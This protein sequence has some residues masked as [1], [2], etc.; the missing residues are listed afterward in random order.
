MDDL[1][2]D[3]LAETREMLEALG[4][5][6]V[7][8]EDDP[9]DRAR[10]DAIFRF[11]H[12]VKGNCGFFEFPRLEALSHAAEDALAD[13]RANRRQADSTLVSA[14]LAILDRIGDMADAIEEGTEFPAGGDEGL[15]AALEP[16][17]DVSA[18]LQSS[19]VSGDDGQHKLPS[20]QRS[21]RL[22][23]E[24]LDRVMSGVSDMV[25][26]RNELARRL[27]ESSVEA[28]VGEP[29]ERLSAII[30][31]VRDA[32]TRTRMQ[33][34]ESLFGG[35]P[36]LVRDLSAELGKQTMIDVDGGEVE[37]DREMI[38]IIRNPLT[39]I[40][41]NAIDHGIETPAARL[42]AG[43]RDMGLLSITARQ[44]G[45]QILIDI[46]DDGRGIDDTRLVEKAVA[47]GIIGAAHATRLSPRERTALIFEPG[48]STAETVTAISGRGVGMDVV[49]ANIERIGGTIEVESI[50]GTGTRFSL[51][52]PLTLTI[53]P[54]LT[55]SIAGQRFA[56]PRSS[57]EEIARVDAGTLEMSRVGGAMLAKIRERR[58]PCLALADLLRMDSGVAD[59]E[60]TLIVLR[61]TGGELFALAVDRV[62]DH[63]ELVV[64]PVAPAIIAAGIYAGTT[65][66]DDG[67]PILLLEATG[68]ARAGG[69]QFDAL[70]RSMR[71]AG[72][73]EAAKAA[74]TTPVLLFIGRDGRRKAMPMAVVARIEEVGPGAVETDGDR[75]RVV[76]GDRILPLAGTDEV[77]LPDEE[78]R[79]FRL[80]DGRTEIGYAIHEALGI[81]QIK[82]EFVAADHSGDIAGVVLID[83]EPTSV[84]APYKLF[85]RHAARTSGEAS[86]VCHLPADDPWIQNF[87]RPMV[88]AAGYRI[89]NDGDGEADLA[90]MTQPEDGVAISARKVIRLRSE[91]ADLQDEP[92]SIYRYDHAGLLSALN[93]SRGRQSL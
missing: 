81:R 20:S 52:V 63:E 74:R 40:I 59:E 47:A 6:L 36:R 28:S 88:E 16:E 4:G 8:W 91:P 27:R 82:A 11:F 76:I 85:A 56:I 65:L 54:A 19:L 23:V 78:L 64:K 75:M 21:I 51:R 61:L 46:V 71:Q 7:A 62:H 53:I 18:L 70:E 84:I 58:L 35:M 17:A 9:G 41:R 13:V 26:A 77:P 69:L 92:D 14:V 48:I 10:L 72:T 39:H 86:P 32:M 49:R 44:S 30:A 67:N 80:H 22:P 34:I 45:N 12:T 93:L 55:V 24:L 38:E 42:A 31:D 83:G 87:V 90:I 68:L 50:P 25:L 3:F 15:I 89:I 66:T 5:E 57:I 60:R 1:L 73:P 79:L 33:R 29:F 37:L 2:A 43:K